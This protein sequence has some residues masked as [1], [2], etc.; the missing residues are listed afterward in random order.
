MRGFVGRHA[1]WRHLA[2]IASI[3]LFG[4]A[5]VALFS[6]A[7]R[8]PVEA[9]VRADS[10]RPVD[11]VAVFGGYTSAD[12][13]LTAIDMV[14]SGSAHLLLSTRAGV[15]G[16]DTTGR[17]QSALM[18]ATDVIAAWRN[19]GEAGNTHEE[20]VHVAEYARKNRLGSLA[21]VTSPLHTRRACAAVERAFGAPVICVPAVE[22]FPVTRLAGDHVNRLIALEQYAY[23][24]LA[25][26]HYRRRGWVTSSP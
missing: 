16:V 14:R 22:R 25:W 4:A 11:A 21:V 18:E 6:P 19:V 1:T 12:R 8:G 3:G 20:A 15:S 5:G 23:E 9:W 13:L 2:T 17:D 10:I 24:R 7:M 26:L